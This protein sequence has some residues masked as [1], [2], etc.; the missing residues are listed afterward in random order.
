MTS[1]SPTPGNWDER[2]RRLFG[3][4]SALA[5]AVPV[6]SINVAD[7]VVGDQLLI[8]AE[9]FIV[10][11]CEPDGPVINIE[12]LSGTRTITNEY[13]RIERVEVLSPRPPAASER[14]AFT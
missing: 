13:L 10:T 12:A 1:A 9:P 4:R 7:L 8:S 14:K 6:L 2:Y 5:E 3:L 11:G